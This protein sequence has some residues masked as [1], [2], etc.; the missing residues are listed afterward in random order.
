MMP[1]VELLTS[2]VQT[3]Y[4]ISILMLFEITLNLFIL[5]KYQFSWVPLNHE[6]QCYMKYKFNVDITWKNC[7]GEPLWTRSYSS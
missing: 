1:L 5:I 7:A 3:F 2:T 4:S 6:I